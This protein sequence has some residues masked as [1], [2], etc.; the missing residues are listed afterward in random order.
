[1]SRDV[2]FAI[3]TVGLYFLFIERFK[4]LFVLCSSKLQYCVVSNSM[5]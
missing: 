5:N 2:V 4:V 3:G 1:M